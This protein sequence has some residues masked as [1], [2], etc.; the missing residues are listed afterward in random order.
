MNGINRSAIIR[1]SYT[2][3]KI[4]FVSQSLDNSPE[5]SDIKSVVPK[6]VV[7][8]IPIPTR[9]LG[10]ILLTTEV[11]SIEEF[12]HIYTLSDDLISQKT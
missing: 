5:I 12:C 3:I 11:V 7:K 9:S 10:A 8:A 2:S 6:D 1:I 4:Q